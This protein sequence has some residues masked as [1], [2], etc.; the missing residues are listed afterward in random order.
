MSV[1]RMSSLSSALVLAVASVGFGAPPS[2]LAASTIKYPSAACPINGDHGLQDCIDGAAAGDTIVLTSEIN[3]DGAVSINKSLTLRATDRS[4]QPQLPFIGIGSGGAPVDVTVQDVRVRSWVRVV[5]A[6]TPGGHKVTLRRLS[7]GR[8]DPNS[9][10]IT[11]DTQSPASLTIEGSYVRNRGG[12]G[13]EALHLFA[14]DPDGL[15]EIRL[16]GNRLTTRGNPG[17]SSGVQLVAVGDGT[18][19][20]DHPQQRDLGCRSLCLRR[21]LGDRGG[22]Q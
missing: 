20:R 14:E 6:T 9:N 4:L 10:G 11:F 18:L 3:P 22:D 17:S 12:S 19:A 15:V 16:I 2:V 13:D 8:D 7:V 21:R 5:F 1:R